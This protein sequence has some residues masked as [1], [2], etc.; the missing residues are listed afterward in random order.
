[1]LATEVEALLV[2][3]ASEMQFVVQGDGRNF[4]IEAVAEA[5]EGSSR[6]KRQQ[7]VYKLIANEIADGQL[8]AITITA[9]TPSEKSARAG[10]GV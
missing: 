7:A 1:M 6:L 10:L 3:R 9:L 4:Q 8:H 2:S 5:F